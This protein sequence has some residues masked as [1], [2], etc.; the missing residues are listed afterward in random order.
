MALVSVI[1]PVF[2]AAH[3]V[4]A[5][6]SSI[7][8]QTFEDWELVAVDD[9]ST[10]E[11]SKLLEA[12]AA[13][14]RRI[15]VHRLTANRGTAT[16]LNEGLAIAAGRFIA[17]MDA[18]DIALRERLALQLESMRRRP[19]LDVLGGLAIRFNARGELGLM[20]RAEDH[21]AIVADI[22]RRC[23]FIHSTVLARREFFEALGG[24]DADFRRCQDKDL[25]LRGYRRFQYHNLQ[26]PLIYKRLRDRH[27][28]R[29]R[30][31]SA[32]CDGRAIGRALRREGRLDRW[33]AWR[34]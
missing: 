18:D 32:S 19:S 17:R 11:T 25:W 12:T 4:R 29:G 28:I 2:N 7:Q 10:D 1:M 5:A 30:L 3:H 20:T 33:R 27:P 13:E 14:D 8:R 16:A 15:Q 9:G 31:L 22:F 24:Y 21:D 23:P 6:V 34:P 26:E